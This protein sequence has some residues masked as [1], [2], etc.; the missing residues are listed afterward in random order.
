M[1]PQVGYTN[2][3]E[4]ETYRTKSI[5]TRIETDNFSNVL[6]KLSE[7]IVQSPLQQGLKPENYEFSWFLLPDLIV[8]S[9]LQQGLKHYKKL[10]ITQYEAYLIVQ[11]PLQQGLKLPHQCSASS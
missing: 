11:S 9:P 7:L 1:K 4:I 6:K 3:E 2:P 10:N 8:Q 5:T